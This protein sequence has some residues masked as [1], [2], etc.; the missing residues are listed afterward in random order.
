MKKENSN[1]SPGQ[2]A[3]KAERTKPF[4]NLLTIC[5]LAIAL[6]TLGFLLIRENV[7]S[8]FLGDLF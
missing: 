7:D 3:K 8:N 6:L 1:P 5:L 2:Q 4:F